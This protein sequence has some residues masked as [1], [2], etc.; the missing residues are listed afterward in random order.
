[1]PIIE[2]NAITH[3]TSG[4]LNNQVVL[5]QRAGRTILA[6]RPAKSTKPPTEKQLARRKAFKEAINYAKGAMNNEMLRAKYEAR[7]TAFVSAYN[8]AVR[9]YLKKPE[10]KAVLQD[11][12]NA[13]AGSR[14]LIVAVDDMEIARV[15]V[16]LHN[17]AG[18]TFE[19]GEATMAADKP[20]YEYV[21]QSTM[22]AGESVVA[23]VAAMDMPG[24][25]TEN[26]TVILNATGI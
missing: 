18:I 25:R 23:T 15:E 13:K 12:Y 17:G 3:G 20:V 9:D 10:I 21:L 14:L 26:E 2:Q 7:E 5:R 22:P 19:Q 6:Y 4:M 16:K 11:D 24:N 8:L 1:M